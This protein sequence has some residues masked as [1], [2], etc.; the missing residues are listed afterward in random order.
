MN[1]FRSGINLINQKKIELSDESM[2]GLIFTNNLQSQIK[3]AAFK[4]VKTDGGA[5]TLGV[6][7]P[8]PFKEK[9]YEANYC[10][11]Y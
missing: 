2:G 4:I 11:D 6:A 5:I 3:K 10:I 1:E 9:N 8:K 7:N